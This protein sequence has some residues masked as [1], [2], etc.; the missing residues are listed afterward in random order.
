MKIC[1]VCKA[2]CDDFAEVCAICGAFLIEEE[3]ETEETFSTAVD[4]DLLEDPTLVATVEDVVSAEI[5]KDIL[6]DNEINYYSDADMDNGAMQVSFGGGFMA[7]QIYVSA[8]D[9]DL[10][11]TLYSEFLKSEEMMQGFDFSDDFDEEQ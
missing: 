8:K 5:F 9:A 10:A 4:E 2:E 11:K 7:E 3:S 1:H 6:A